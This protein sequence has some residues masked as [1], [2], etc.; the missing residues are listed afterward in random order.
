MRTM[1]GIIVLL[2]LLIAL[3]VYA[4]DGT[5]LLQQV[6]RNLSPDSYESYRKLINIEPSGAKK[7]FTL[8]TVKKG[9][10]LF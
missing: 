1:K 4:L 9:L 10:S 5:A 7:E 6:D 2:S 8:F 3:P